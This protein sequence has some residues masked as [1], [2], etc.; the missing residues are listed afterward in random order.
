MMVPY[1]FDILVMPSQLVLVIVVA[2]LV[3]DA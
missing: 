3:E 2:L 1:I